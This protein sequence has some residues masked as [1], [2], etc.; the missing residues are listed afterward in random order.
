MSVKPTSL[1]DIIKRMEQLLPKL[2]G[3]DIELSIGLG[4]DLAILADAGLIEQVLMNIATNARGPCPTA[5]R[6]P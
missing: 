5:D 3:E 2:I 1:N 4:D 6:W